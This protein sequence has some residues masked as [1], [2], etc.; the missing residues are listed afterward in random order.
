MFV[1]V[2]A[3][4]QAVVELAEELVEQVPLSLVVPVSGRAAGVEVAAGA[5]GGAQRC[6]RPDRADGSE[7]PV[8]DMP[9]QHNDFLAAG[10]GDRSGSSEGFE[11]AGIGETSAVITDLGQRPGT[12]QVPQPG[13]AGDD[14]GVRVLLKMG[15]RRLDQLLGRGAD[16]GE[17][18]QHP[19]P[20][21][22]TAAG[23]LYTRDSVQAF[24]QRWTATRNPRGGPRRRQP[25]TARAAT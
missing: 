3:G 11:P 15:D 10:A 19:Q 9:M 20:V 1:I 24:N 6:Q 5:W 18:A 8:L 12:G 16:G 13:K 25:A 14:L 7:A 2:L 22:R 4:V 23:R 21:A 17:L